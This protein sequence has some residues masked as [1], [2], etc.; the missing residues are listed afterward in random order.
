LFR[1]RAAPSKSLLL[2]EF[3]RENIGCG[4]DG[5]KSSSVTPTLLEA[6]LGFEAI[7]K[8]N[9]DWLK[10]EHGH[11]L[12]PVE[13]GF[14]NNPHH[15]Q[16]GGQ[17]LSQ[18]KLILLLDFIENVC[19][20]EEGN[21]GESAGKDDSDCFMAISSV[22][23]VTAARTV[24]YLAQNRLLDQIPQLCVDIVE[25]PEVALLRSMIGNGSST[26]G[27]DATVVRLWIGGTA[28]ITPLHFDRRHNILCQIYGSK[29]VYLYRPLCPATTKRAFY[30]QSA[31][32]GESN[33]S[34]VD[35]ENPNFELH[36]DF[37]PEPDM[38]CH[39]VRGDALFIPEGWWHA[40]KSL[41]P[42]ISVNFWW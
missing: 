3:P 1:K 33:A 35:V 17:P 22:V 32:G 37:P 4:F 23:P 2:R 6:E 21:S 13:V 27:G 28:S 7:G 36:P 26:P 14:A 38:C 40:V 10:M 41:E 8:W 18:Q 25:P 12:V 20:K 15:D 29:V 42:S 30:P 9:M 39:L 31:F 16:E 11:R 5:F 19:G 24:A 34:S